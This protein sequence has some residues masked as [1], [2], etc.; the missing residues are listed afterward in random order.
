MCR[1]FLVFSLK[2][3]SRCVS[4]WAYLYHSRQSRETC[5]KNKWFSTF[6]WSLLS[7]KCKKFLKNNQ[8][9][10]FLKNRWY[11]YSGIQNPRICDSK[12]PWTSC[13]LLPD[14]K[15]GTGA[16]RSKKCPSSHCQIPGTESNASQSQSW[17]F[18]L[19]PSEQKFGGRGQGKT[20]ESGCCEEVFIH[21]IQV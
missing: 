4:P 17:E 10:V 16:Q 3:C 19:S 14:S 13:S 9:N 6:I 18:H 5:W 8:W 20:W 11:V 2:I 15:E 1:V 21:F 12:K 7:S